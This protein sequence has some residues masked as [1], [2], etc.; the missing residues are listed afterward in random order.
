MSELPREKQPCGGVHAMS[1]R[2]HSSQ[3]WATSRAHTLVTA[4][5]TSQN[6]WGLPWIRAWSTY[7]MYPTPTRSSHRQKLLQN[8]P[9]LWGVKRILEPA[10]VAFCLNRDVLEQEL[11]PRSILYNC[12]YFPQRCW[13]YFLY[14]Q[15][16]WLHKCTKNDNH[17]TQAYKNISHLCYSLIIVKGVEYL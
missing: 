8:I 5:S 6:T 11:K 10:I 17:C 4:P 3:I 1:F 9:C 14:L 13:S 2:V 12:K 7:F 15:Y 16:P